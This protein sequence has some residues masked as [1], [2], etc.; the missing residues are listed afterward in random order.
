M[1]RIGLLSDSHGRAATTQQAVRLLIDQQIDLLLH[2]GDIGSLEVID[3]MIEQV[4]DNGRLKPPVRLVF[5]NVDWDADSLARYA[6]SLGV[7][8]D[9]PMGWLEMDGKTLVYQH[10]HEQARMDQALARGVDYLCHGHTH[11][12]R[13]ETLGSTRLIN[14]GAL[15]RAADY[16]VAVLDTDTGQVQFHSLRDQRD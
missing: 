3:A 6:V 8:V 7:D 1:A 16:T 12:P 15:F 14:P 9:H 10:G 5:G 11:R 13:N 2:L 4:D